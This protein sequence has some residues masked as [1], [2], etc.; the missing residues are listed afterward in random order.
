[1]L[2]GQTPMDA[3]SPSINSLKTAA[4]GLAVFDML[5]KAAFTPCP[6]LLDP[7]KTICLNSA[8]SCRA[9]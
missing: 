7:A 9:L 5:P 4:S 2:W 1:M 3:F 6:K 8:E